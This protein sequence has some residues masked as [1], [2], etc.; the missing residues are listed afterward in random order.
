MVPPQPWGATAAAAHQQHLAATAAVPPPGV[1][2]K[3]MLEV[4]RQLLH[5]PPGMYASPSAAEQWCHDVDQLVITAINMPPHGGRQPNHLGGAPLPSAAHSCP[6]VAPRASLAVRAPSLAMADLRAKLECHLSGEDDCI[7]I[8]RQWERRR[9]L[10]RDFGAVDTT[11]V[12]QDARTPTSSVGSGGGCMVL[13]PH[14]HMVVWLHLLE[15]YDGSVNSAKFLQIYS[16]LILNAGG[17]E[18]SWP[19]TSRW[20]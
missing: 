1:G 4:A 14:L 10:D 16:T 5:N 15:K 20:P 13:A 17:N 2:P 11:P 6:L 12:K 3:D 19:T 8:G 18:A 9:N 7:T